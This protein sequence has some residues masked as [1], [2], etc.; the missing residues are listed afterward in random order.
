VPGGSCGTAWRITRTEVL[1]A[2]E[3]C[4]SE[5]VTNAVVHSGAGPDEFVM[6][7]LVETDERIRVE[8]IDN[9][10]GG[11]PLAETQNRTRDAESGS[12]EAEDGRGLLIVAVLSAAFGVCGDGDGKSVWFEVDAQ[13]G[14]D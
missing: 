4:T 2:V 5:T 6:L 13:R 10:H 14:K 12:A 7:V 3:L 8:V 11:L 1:D 9:G